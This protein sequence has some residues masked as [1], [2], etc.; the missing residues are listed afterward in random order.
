MGHECDLK[1]DDIESR[2][3]KLFTD[4]TTV[5]LLDHIIYTAGIIEV[6]PVPEV[7]VDYLRSSGQLAFVAPLVVAKL[8]P[9]FLKSD[10]T[11]SL[12]FTS[13]RVAERPLANYS[14]AAYYAAGLYGLTRNL[15]LDLAPL[16]V[17][18]VSPGSTDTE[19]WGPNRAQMREMVAKN[20]L[21][22]KAGTA[23]EVAEAYVY[24]M[25]NTDATGSCVSTNG[26]ALL[27]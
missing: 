11:S 21:L 24:L 22:G 4:V 18:L 16:R 10:Y 1:N 12:I 23:E 15:A 5:G 19:L 3:E 9:R 17:N 25:K 8:A 7:D 6:K 27:K 2:L 20:A 14:V 13:G 26:G